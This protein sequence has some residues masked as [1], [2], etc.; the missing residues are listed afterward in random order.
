MVLALSGLAWRRDV[1]RVAGIGSRSAI[2]ASGRLTYLL[3]H[4]ASRES[5]CAAPSLA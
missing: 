5:Y 1:Y 2:L 3:R 4:L